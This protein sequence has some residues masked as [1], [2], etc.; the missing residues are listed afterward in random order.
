M[1]DK[2]A[3]PDDVVTFVPLAPEGHGRSESTRCRRDLLEP[4]RCCL[5]ALAMNSS[6]FFRRMVP[7]VVTRL[8]RKCRDTRRGHGTRV[9]AGRGPVERG[10]RPI[11]GAP[12]GAARH[13][14]AAEALKARCWVTRV[15]RGGRIASP[16][17]VLCIRSCAPFCWALG[18]EDCAGAECPDAATTR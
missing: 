4:D 1:G 2:M 18:G 11:S 13:C 14:R 3:R 16:L 9:G 12:R 15:E 10:R 17:R 7:R 8:T 5:S 6:R